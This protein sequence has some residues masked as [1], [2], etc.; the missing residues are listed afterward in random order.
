VSN[1]IPL[2]SSAHGNVVLILICVFGGS[3]MDLNVIQLAHAASDLLAPAMPYLMPIAAEA[4]KE[5]VKRT[6]G[7]ITDATFRRAEELWEKISP[8]I[9][10]KPAAMEA[11]TDLAKMPEDTDARVAFSFQMRKLLAAD[12]DLARDVANLLIDSGVHVTA[13]GD[14]SVAANTVA[15]SI[16]MTGDQK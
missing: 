9:Q 1:L 8:R 14:R 16:I 3:I 13:S 6:V 2:V 5:V 12:D 11:A 7:T 4:G 15:D 10:A